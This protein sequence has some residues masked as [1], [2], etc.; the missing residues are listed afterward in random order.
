[1]DINYD[2]LKDMVN[3][4]DSAKYNVIDMQYKIARM[5]CS[6]DILVNCIRIGLVKPCVPT[7]IFRQV[8][9]SVR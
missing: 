6:S 1:M 4:L 9:E 2:R 5:I 3:E 7:N 8:L